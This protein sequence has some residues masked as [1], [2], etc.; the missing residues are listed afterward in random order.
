MITHNSTILTQLPVEFGDIYF[1]IFFPYEHGVLLFY[2]Q[3]YNYV[4]TVYW[5]LNET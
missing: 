5:I 1:Q 2:K 3:S 4:I